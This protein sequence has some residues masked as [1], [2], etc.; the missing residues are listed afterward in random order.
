MRPLIAKPLLLAV[1]GQSAGYAT[2]WFADPPGLWT[3]SE[4]IDLIWTWNGVQ[5][6]TTLNNMWRSVPA[7]VLGWSNYYAYINPDQYCALRVCRPDGCNPDPQY[8]GWSGGRLYSEWRNF[9]FPAC[10]GIEVDAFYSPIALRGKND[11]SMIAS[12]SW[13]LTGPSCIN[14]LTPNFR[15][16]RTWN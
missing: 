7:Y 10:Y 15:L 11:G 5:D 6:C 16:V 14:L 9:V 13:S 4:Q 2:G 1:P 12:M 3:N 8:L